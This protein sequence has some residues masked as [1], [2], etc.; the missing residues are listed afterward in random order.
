MNRLTKIGFSSLLPASTVACG[1]T[2]CVS[3]TRTGPT[4]SSICQPNPRGN[5]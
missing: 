4:T 5:R 3:W 1:G 2:H